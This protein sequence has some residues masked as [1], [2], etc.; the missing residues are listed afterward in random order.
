[1]GWSAAKGGWT[2]G[3]SAVVPGERAGR[4]PGKGAGARFSNYSMGTQVDSVGPRSRRPGRVVEQR[5]ITIGG[6]AVL[7]ALGA[8]MAA[9][10]LTWLIGLITNL[11]FYGRVSSSFSSP[12]NNHLGLLV[13]VVPVVGGV[14]V[15]VMA[16]YGSRA[17]RGHG[18]PEA[19]EQVLFNESR[20]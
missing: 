8:S 13:L 10:L 5:V 16:R 1:S 7:G 2:Y 9:R 11:A 6:L 20:F 15:C 4:L 18:I 14:V 19:M 12:A 17:I 3:W